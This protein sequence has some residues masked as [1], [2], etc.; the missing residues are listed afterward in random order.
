MSK[1]N[2]KESTDMNKQ[3]ID[4]FVFKLEDILLL[5]LLFLLTLN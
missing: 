1:T 5:A 3:F 4:A 2:K